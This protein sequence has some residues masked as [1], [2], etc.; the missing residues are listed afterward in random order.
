MGGATLWQSS[1]VG[2]LLRCLSSTFSWFGSLGN[3]AF[4]FVGQ[5]NPAALGSASARVWPGNRYGG[6]LLAPAPV[7]KGTN[8]HDAGA[9]LGRCQ[10]GPPGNS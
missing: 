3:S 6:S 5:A 7:T 10:H 8:S 1:K 2:S 9:G 4:S